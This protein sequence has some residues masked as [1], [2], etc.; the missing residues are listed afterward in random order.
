MSAPAK[1]SAANA[2]KLSA[3]LATQHPDLFRALYNQVGRLQRSP[4]GRL[5]YF[6]D[7]TDLTFTPDLPAVQIAPDVN[8]DSTAAYTPDLQSVADFSPDTSTAASGFGDSLTSSI[9]A[10]ATPVASDPPAASSFWSGIGSGASSVAS[11]VGKVASALVSP[12]SIVA[13]G[14]AAAAFFTAQGRSAQAQAQNAIVQAQLAR[15][16]QGASPASLSYVTN[17]LTGQVTPVYNTP[18]GQVPVTGP[19]LN[20]LSSPTV[21]GT[22]AGIPTS[23]V[24]IGGGL[25]LL[26][27]FLT[28]ARRN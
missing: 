15:T 25:A 24:L 19:L 5:G 13:V 3:W 10:P 12:A 17:P 20:R 27:L 18:A 6:G 4:L 14:G 11:A 7:S 22:I 21:S 23:T 16:A 8:Y 1:I 26:A 9:A 2:I 28:A